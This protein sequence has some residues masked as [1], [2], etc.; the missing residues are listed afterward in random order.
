MSSTFLSFIQQATMASFN[1]P[2]TL[3]AEDAALF[4]SLT[5]SALLPSLAK[6]G[7]GE[8]V[9]LFKQRKKEEQK[10]L[11]L[12][13]A[14]ILEDELKK[15]LEKR[16]ED[17]L[18]Q[19]RE[20]KGTA[21]SVDLFAWSTVAYHESLSQLKQRQSEMTYDQRMAHYA[22]QREK[23]QLIRE[24]KWETMFSTEYSHV[25]GYDEDAE[26]DV[27]RSPMK[28]DRIFRCSDLA[29]RLS[30]A[31]GPNFFPYTR[32]EYVDGRDSY[33][34]EGF[35][36][37]KKVLGVRYHPFGVS[38]T[39]MRQLL[40]VAKSEASRLEK[41]EKVGLTGGEY[42]VGH[43]EMCILPEAEYADMPP[44]IPASM[45]GL[46]IGAAERAGITDWAEALRGKCFCGCADDDAE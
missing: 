8:M 44:L 39:Q 16:K 40:A 28:V 9:E 12:S 23:D 33:A 11:V 26:T 4:S 13:H 30:L 24:N 18:Q 19:L 35:S 46:R 5:S 20:S 2:Y 38:Q 1:L 3:S 25:Y 36:V 14:D 42:A 37:Y 10:Q 17:I 15:M 7:E 41:G 22:A 21:F 45:A 43:E 31:L 32:W 34:K 27:T 6:P 29:M